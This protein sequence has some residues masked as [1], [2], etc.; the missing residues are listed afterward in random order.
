MTSRT[1]LGIFIAST[2]AAAALGGCGGGVETGTGGSGATTSSSSGSS[3]GTASSS[4]GSGGTTSSSSG[5][6]G[7]SAPCSDFTPPPPGG[8]PIT[9]R[10]VNK[11]TGNVY[12]GETTAGC[13]TSIGF[14]LEDAKMATLKPSR[15]ICEFTCAELQQGSCACPA[16][17]AAPIVTLVGPGQHYDVGWPGTIFVSEDMPAKC[18]Q[19]MICVNGGGC[20]VEQAPPMETL[21]MRASAWSMAVCPG[22]PGQT[23]VD[24]VPGFSGSCIVPGAQTVGGTE[25]KGSVQ[26]NMGQGIAEIDFM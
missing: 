22:N 24:C 1:F 6:T 11:T 5:G 17:C 23:C 21:T 12:L 4:S 7:G 26:W 2:L 25:I 10:L 15:D 20:L 14:T 8:T 13:S 16:G 19:D 3:S 9:V 18:Y